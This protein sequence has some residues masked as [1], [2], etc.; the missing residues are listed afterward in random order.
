M[1]V[2]RAHYD[3]LSNEEFAW[4]RNGNK[5]H[6]ITFAVLLWSVKVFNREPESTF[7]NLV[8]V[9]AQVIHRILHSND[10]IKFA[11]ILNGFNESGYY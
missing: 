11:Q 8:E 2:W 6:A 10:Q 4:E 1:E 5:M 3:K 9:K 7:H